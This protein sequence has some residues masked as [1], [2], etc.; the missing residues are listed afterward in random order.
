MN[1]SKKLPTWSL[2]VKEGDRW[3]NIG[4][5][6]ETDR[7]NLFVKLDEGVT[8]RGTAMF[9]PY[10]EKPSGG[11]AYRKWEAKR[12]LPPIG[13]AADMAKQG[14]YMDRKR[15]ERSGKGGLPPSEPY[16]PPSPP[17][18]QDMDPDPEAPDWL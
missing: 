14:D 15:R 12:P 1:A 11:G 4:A 16:Y 10:R 17:S 6:W 9:F 7:G 18:P 3:R 2:C 5:A 8:L 13:D